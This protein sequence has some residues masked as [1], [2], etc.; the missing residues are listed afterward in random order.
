MNDKLKLSYNRIRNDIIFT[1]FKIKSKANQYIL[2]IVFARNVHILLYSPSHSLCAFKL[3]D[4]FG[5]VG[6]SKY[7]PGPGF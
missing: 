2:F 4:R 5:T 3:S 7:T 1:N 6:W